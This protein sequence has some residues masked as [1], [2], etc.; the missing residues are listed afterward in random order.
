MLWRGA[1]VVLAGEDGQGQATQ[2]EQGVLPAP[3]TDQPAFHRHHQELAE[4]A[5]RSR[6][7]HGPRAPLS[8]HIAADDTVHHRIGGA[9]LGQPQQDA[10]TS[11]EGQSRSGQCHQHETQGI[12]QAACDQRLEGTKTIG[13]QAGEGTGQA[14]AKAKVSRV[15]PRSIVMGA[16]HRP[17]PC[18]MPID[19]VT[20]RAPQSSTCFMDKDG[21]AAELIKPL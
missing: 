20:M 9:R 4:R 2:H 19:R 15:Q 11:G 16:S 3:G 1:P 21:E 10:R 8:R 12:Q 13:Q 17:K 14:R 5:R 18:R 7:P 6:H